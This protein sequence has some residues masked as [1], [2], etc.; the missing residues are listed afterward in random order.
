M[1]WMTDSFP[2]RGTDGIFSLSHHIQTISGGKVA[3]IW[4]W[5]L[6]Y[7]QWRCSGEWRYYSMHS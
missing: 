3:R 5:S 2:G 1:N 6:T 7:I 4:S